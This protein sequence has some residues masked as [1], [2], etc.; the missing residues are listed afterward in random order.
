[1][2]VG[3]RN[4]EGGGRLDQYTSNSIRQVL[5]VKGSFADAWSYDTYAQVGITQFQDIEGN[6]LGV[7]QI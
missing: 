5:G 3:R 7:P 6:F 4:V 1:M 2:Y